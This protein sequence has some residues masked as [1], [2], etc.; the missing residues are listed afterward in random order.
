MVEGGI[1]MRTMARY[2]TFVS[3]SRYGGPDPD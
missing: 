1:R 2:P 3:E